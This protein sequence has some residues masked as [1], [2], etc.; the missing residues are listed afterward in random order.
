MLNI[1]LQANLINNFGIV[2]QIIWWMGS[3]IAIGLGVFFTNRMKKYEVSSKFI[4]GLAIFSYSYGIA[5]IIENIRKYIISTDARDIFNAWVN[6]G[7]ITDA[8][9]ILRILYYAIAWTGIAI[10]YFVSE[11]YIFKT[12]TH[13]LMTL[14][15]IVEGIASILNYVDHLTPYTIWI[16]AVGYFIAAIFPIVLYLNMARVNTGVIRTSCIWVALGLLFFIL[17]VLADLPE[18]LYV[19]YIT[20]GTELPTFITSVLAPIALFLGLVIMAISFKKMF[21]SL[22]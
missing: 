7:Q 14:A 1:I 21:S 10:F 22:I 18:S 8:N 9:Y 15:S 13:Y 20:G 19:I 16:S 11:R 6:G 4:L 17:G 3:F 2:E 5:R 12:K